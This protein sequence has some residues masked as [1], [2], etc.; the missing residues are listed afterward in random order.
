MS[1]AFAE[2]GV[3]VSIGQS[4]R[5]QRICMCSMIYRA[6]MRS[7]LTIAGRSGKKKQSSRRTRNRTDVNLEHD[8]THPFPLQ[9]LPSPNLPNLEIRSALSSLTCSLIFILLP[10]ILLNV[11]EE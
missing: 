8:G 2:M 9:N 5:K 4:S 6:K 11:S 7:W 10:P 1:R 3:G